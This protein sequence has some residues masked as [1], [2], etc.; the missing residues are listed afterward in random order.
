ERA[1]FESLISRFALSLKDHLRSMSQQ[2]KHTDVPLPLT[3]ANTPVAIGQEIYA[4]LCMYHREGEIDSE[5]LAML[6][7]HARAL[8]DVLGTCERISSSPITL[9]HKSILLQIIG[10]YIICLPWALA[11]AMGYFSVPLV[12]MGAYMVLGLEL[13]AEE[14]EHPFGEGEEDLPLERF[15]DTIDRSAKEILHIA[16]IKQ[17]GRD[18][19]AQEK[20]EASR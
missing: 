18:T 2:P 16:H 14:K 17:P 8:M 6:D 3:E 12:V 20:G 11:P 10:V 5:V 1:E 19:D 4:R 9:A 13:I 7:L 15:C